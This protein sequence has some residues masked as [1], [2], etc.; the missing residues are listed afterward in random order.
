MN[1]DHFDYQI[2]QHFLSALINGDYSGLE[3]TEANQ[4]NVWETSVY[5]EHG[6]TGHWIEIQ[7]SE[8]EFAVCD[9]MLT[10]G[11]VVGVSYLVPRVAKAPAPLW[12][13]RY[14]EKGTGEHTGYYQS[15]D[16][17]EAALMSFRRYTKAWLQEST[18]NGRTWKTLDV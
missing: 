16:G 2:G 10:R 1:F 5:L 12:R 4:F 15:R 9:V 3:S 13:V 11:P 14:M 17:A 6:R 7:D 8:E 18:D